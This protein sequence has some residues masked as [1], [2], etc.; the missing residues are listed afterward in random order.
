ML[1]RYR[2]VTLSALFAALLLAAGAT[3]APAQ[4]VVGFVEEFSGVALGGFTAGSLLS[5]PGTGGYLGSGDGFLRISTAAL[6]NLGANSSLSTAFAGDYLLAGVTEIRLY[7]NDVGADQ[8]IEMHLSIGNT[9]NLW[10]YDTGYSPPNGSWGQYS[11]PL[12][13]PSG[14]TRT[15]GLAGTFAEALQTADR[16]LV[17]HDLAPFVSN[18]NTI[19]GEVGID[20]IELRGNPTPATSNSWGRI[21][22][23]YR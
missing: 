15:V 7:V 17:R 20:H 21:K 8:A 3:S 9:S 1:L 6:A 5:N 16:I 19:L 11:V 4:P 22:R 14:W 2:T 23:L 10:Q 13:G 12:N 18:P